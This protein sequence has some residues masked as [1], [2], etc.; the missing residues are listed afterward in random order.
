M[1]GLGEPR[2]SH[3]NSK[4]PFSLVVVLKRLLLNVGYVRGDALLVRIGRGVNVFRSV[5]Y[6]TE[7]LTH[8][9]KY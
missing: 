3:C 9:Q 7:T 1:L 6:K 4:R 8:I 5:K 2:I